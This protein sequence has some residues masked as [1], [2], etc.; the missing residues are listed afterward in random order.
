[1]G[2][3]YND[4]IA[5]KIEV[6]KPKYRNGFNILKGESPAQSRMTNSFSELII[7]IVYIVAAKAD[8]GNTIAITCGKNKNI[9]SK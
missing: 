7:F 2:T 1:M 9:N 5:V 4:N 8:I 6:R 3:R